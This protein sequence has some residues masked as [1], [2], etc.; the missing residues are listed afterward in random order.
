M[1]KHSE[2][3]ED[4]YAFLKKIKL[5]TARKLDSSF[6]G[7]Y[8]SAVKGMGLVFDSVREYQ[9]GDDV[10][11]IDWNVSA[12]MNHLYIKEY[13]EERDISVLLMIDLSASTGFGLARA[14]KEAVFE[15]ASLLLR[16]VQINNDR[17]SVLL[18]TDRVEKFIKPRKGR[19]VLSV[20]DEIIKCSPKGTGTDIGSAVDFARRVLKRRSVIFC[21]SDFLDEKESYLLK[22]KLL[23]R[24]HDV[25]AVQVYD[26]F[27]ASANF[28]GLMEFIDLET[29]ETFLSDAVP[30][31]NTFPFMQELSSIIIRTD[32]PVELPVLKFF[33]RRGKMKAGRS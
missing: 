18:F 26:P 16:L 2:Q 17:V 22:L 27:E 6:S 32:E 21:V 24:R 14:K 5:S 19:F 11:S 15:L 10:R 13:I 31:K 33:E 4:N 25:I 23:R 1:K 3:P 9:Y 28:S 8:R 12:R 30:G 20:L 29:G 7:E